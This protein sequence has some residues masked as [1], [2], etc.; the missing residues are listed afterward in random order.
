MLFSRKN[1]IPNTED[2][3]CVYTMLSGKYSELIANTARG[4]KKKRTK[5]RK[6]NQNKISRDKIRSIR[7]RCSN[8]K[9][10]VPG[11]FVN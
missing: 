10:Y 5:Q 8:G 1:K 6:K 3:A 2:H 7:I 4:K 11:T 9:C